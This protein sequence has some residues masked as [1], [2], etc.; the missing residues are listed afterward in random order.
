M[1]PKN[2]PGQRP[3]AHEHRRS[4][5]SRCLAMPTVR[6]RRTNAGR[7]HGRVK[8]RNDDDDEGNANAHS[9][10]QT[11]CR[12]PHKAS[13]QRTPYRRSTKAARVQ[14]AGAQVQA[15]S[16]DVVQAWATRMR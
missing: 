1:G 12:A 4:R 7:E 8:F 11:P 6:P 14:L 10:S 5:G 16:S 13:P 3:V 15:T 9:S 2:S